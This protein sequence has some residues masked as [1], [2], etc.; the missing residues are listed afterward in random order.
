MMLKA[1][2]ALVTGSTSGI[3]LA[4]ARALAMQ[5]ANVLLSGLG[6]PGEIEKQRSGMELEFGIKAFHSSADMA[7]PGE[8][9][10]MV[11]QAEEPSARS[12]FW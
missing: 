6:S 2:T 9:V 7:K 8:I 10:A 12:T 5:G 3:G 1:K 11:R 4:V